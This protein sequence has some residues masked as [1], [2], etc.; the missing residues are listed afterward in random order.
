MS[1]I[2]GTSKT[3]GGGYEIDQSIRFDNVDGVNAGGAQMYRLA[4]T[5]TPTNDKKA[6]ISAWVKR[7][8]LGYN[9][10]I[11]YSGDPNGSTF[12]GLRFNTNDTILFSQASSVYTLTTT[13]VFRDVG[14]WYHIVAEID[15]ANGT[16]ADRANLYVNGEKVTSFSTATYPSLNYVTNWTASSASIAHTWGTNGIP[17]AG[18]SS[19]LFAGYMAE[20]Y[21]LDGEKAGPT[22]FGEFNDSGVWIP[23][24]YSG[25]FGNN[26]YH[27]TGENASALGEDFSANNLD[28]TTV[29]LATTDQMLD[30]P[31]DNF[32]TL[33]AV[34]K[35][36]QVVLADG[37]LQYGLSSNSY[38]AVR[39][40]FGISSGK[41]YWEMSTVSGMAV[42]T[43]YM[44][45]ATNASN[46]QVSNA[47]G[48]GTTYTYI[49]YTG[50][51]AYTSGSAYGTA[52]NTNGRV[53]GVALDLDAGKIWWSRDGVWQASGDPAAGTNEAFSGITG[54]WHPYVVFNDTSPNLLFNFG[55]S[56]FTYTPPTGFNTLSTANLP[57][58]SITDGS[59]YFQPT[60]YTGT[61]SS[62]AV[63]QSGNST[64]Q[65]DWVWIKGRS[66]ATE[67][68][69]TDAV[70]GVTKELSSND[71]GAEE[72]VA[73]GLTTF[74]S[75][76]FTVGTDGSYN[77]SSATYVGWQWKANGA[78]SSNTDG[79]ISSTVSADTTSGF[80][81][82]RY[83]GNLS[84][85]GSATVGHG[86]GIAPSVVISKSLDSTAGDSGAWAV[87]HTSLPASNIL[88]LNT[89]AAT[90]DKSGN[91][92]L[93][94]PTST[95][96]YTN[97]TEGLNVTGNDYIAYCF[98]EVEG[99]SSIGSYTGNGSA[100]DGP[101]VYT[102]FRPAFVM[103]KRIDSTS[104]W[105]IEDTTRSTFNLVENALFPNLNIAEDTTGDRMDILSNGFKL[106]TTAQP[107]VGTLIYMAF[108]EHPFGGDGV[109]PATAR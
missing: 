84:T 29:A 25:A 9:Q 61:G 49:S 80:S 18:P 99:F 83:A 12:E 98:A 94:S 35:A 52:W 93:S 57:T 68:V 34:D 48:D 10:T 22:A 2:Q 37:N 108:A 39:G 50:N 89:T 95:V 76:G 11:A 41:W 82:V 86:L 67:H 5:G 16:A 26:G 24:A 44:G 104:D 77:T 71:T 8:T 64:F 45:I 100:T 65:P 13:Q 88:R 59:A 30:T 4:L 58:P 62:L 91:G 70:R 51:K 42:N 79:T 21:V 14:A 28:F 73:Q 101:F 3:A 46:L 69:L 23:K 92:T 102:G 106:R 1:I 27:Q 15:T 55:Q 103:T 56:A 105:T 60:L 72:T 96:F 109:A 87:Q 43:C 33:N 7:A 75:A 31:T 78:G 6:T 32:C 38:T 17:A 81:I 74:G 19:Q 47:P 90:S 20:M 54:T 53:I 40:T 107:N 63:T 66:G 36:T 85:T 97:Y